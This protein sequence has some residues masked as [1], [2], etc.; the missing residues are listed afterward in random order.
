[1]A[2]GTNK[3][4]DSVKKVLIYY[5]HKNIKELICLILYFQIYIYIYY[6]FYIYILYFQYIYSNILYIHDTWRHFIIFE[7]GS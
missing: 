1:M 5:R 2:G 7:S 3:S 4:F 6:I